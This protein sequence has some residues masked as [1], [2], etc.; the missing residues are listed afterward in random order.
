MLVEAE[1][2][3][4]TVAT[5]GRDKLTAGRPCCGK[6]CSWLVEPPFERP[7]LLWTVTKTCSSVSH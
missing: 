3:C 6:I 5:A 1:R 2:G 7:V 4:A